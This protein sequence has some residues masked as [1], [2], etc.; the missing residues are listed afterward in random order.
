MTRTRNRARLTAETISRELAREGIRIHRI[1]HQSNGISTSVDVTLLDADPFIHRRAREICE[2]YQVIRED[3]SVDGGIVC[4]RR[5]DLPQVGAVNVS[6]NLSDHL[7]AKIVRYL[8][9]R[10]Q[11]PADA[12]TVWQFFEGRAG[13]FWLHHQR[14]QQAA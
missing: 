5:S 6:N 7:Y 12:R 1:S 9:E 14:S 3:A 10:A 13:D 2:R 4:N 8:A 11:W